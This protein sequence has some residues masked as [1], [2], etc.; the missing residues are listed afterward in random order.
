MTTPSHKLSG[1][2]IVE[3]L[4]VIVVIGILAAVT[5][6]AF[7]GVQ[8]RARDTRRLSTINQL[9]K[10]IEAHYAINGSYPT[11]GGNISCTSTGYA[12]DIKT[13]VSPAT[14]DDPINTN[15]SWGFYYARGYRKTSVNSYQQT[16]NDQSYV[17]A[18]RLE[19][20]TN[21][22]FNGWNNASLNYLI[23]TN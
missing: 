19:G 17:I 10:Q 15:G 12:G 23:G 16:N 4:I 13:L 8:Q 20:G 14:Q 22:T 3:L 1:F 18:T 21:P 7:N 6:V 2:T 5:I 9:Q 11:C